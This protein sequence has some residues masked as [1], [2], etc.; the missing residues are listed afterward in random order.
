MHQLIECNEPVLPP[1][2]I[3]FYLWLLSK[4]P[5]GATPLKIAND[6]RI[7]KRSVQRKAQ[8]LQDVG[9]LDKRNVGGRIIYRA[10]K[11]RDL[12]REAV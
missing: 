6:R 7:T 4:Y 2:V 5:N 9:R 11:N 1:S 3:V 10:V 8:C 12:S